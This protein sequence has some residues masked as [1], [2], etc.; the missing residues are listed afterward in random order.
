S[1]RAQRRVAILVDDPTTRVIR[2]EGPPGTGKSLTIANLASHLAATGRRVLVTSQKD[3]AL[4][5]VDEK[6]REL[7]LPELPMTLLRQSKTSKQELLDRLSRIKK[8]RPRDEVQRDVETL[9]REYSTAAAELIS[10]SEEY[11]QAI[12]WEHRVERSHRAVLES[13]GLRK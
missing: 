13:K 10:R 6:L 8:E 4:Q 3:K 11:V 12:N 1:N 5:V 2:V 7:G 9:E